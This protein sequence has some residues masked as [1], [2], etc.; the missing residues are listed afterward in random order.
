[1]RTEQANNLSKGAMGKA[2]LYA[3]NDLPRLEHYLRDGRIEIDNNQI[4]NK[5]RPLALGRKNYLF[6]GSSQAAQRAAMV[7]S[8]FASCKAND[9]NPREWLRD[10]L[11]RI[12]NHPV[13]RL[14]ELLPVQWAEKRGMDL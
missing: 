1:V 3:K 6:A 11:I 4:E 5:I 13:N 12:G 7:Y 10:V 2:L 8:F 14:E 9:I